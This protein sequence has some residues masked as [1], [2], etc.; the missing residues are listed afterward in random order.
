MSDTDAHSETEPGEAESRK[1][2]RG[3]WLIVVL[4]AAVALAWWLYQRSIHVYTDDARIATDLVVISSKVA[5]RIEQ[6]AVK[7]GSQVRSGELIVQLDSRETQHRLEELKAQ[8]KATESTIAQAVAELTM[9]ERQTGGALQAVQSQLE[10]AEANL[11]ST[12][13][14]LQLKSAEWERSQSLKTKGIL[15][16]QGW[17]QAA[18]LSRWRSKTRTA[19]ARKL[20]PPRPGWWKQMQPGIASRCWSNSKSG[21]D[22]T[23][24]VSHINWAVSRLSWTKGASIHHWPASSTRSS[25][26]PANTCCPD[27]GSPSFTTPMMCG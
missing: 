8:L 5:G 20:P 25:S 21:W 4:V 14:D 7:E 1:P 13:S 10:A 24:T 2:R 11:A 9:V 16:Q 3:L 27:N 17:E 12:D 22:M 26:T 19:P 6:L 15:S 18:V 23:A